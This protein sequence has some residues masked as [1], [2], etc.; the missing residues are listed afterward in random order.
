MSVAERYAAFRAQLEPQMAKLR[1]AERGMRSQWARHG[2]KRDGR[3]HDRKPKV[4]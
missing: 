3:S 2:K 4:K 1:E